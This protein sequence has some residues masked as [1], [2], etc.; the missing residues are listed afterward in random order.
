MSKNIKK[1]LNLVDNHLSNLEE[2]QSLLEAI[3]SSTQDA[4]SVVNH[5]GEHIMINPAYTKIT[6][7]KAEDILGTNA[8]FDVGE[9]ESVHM[10]VLRTST[11]VTGVTIKLRPSGKIVIAQAA[12]IIVDNKLIGSVAGLKDVTE[13]NKLTNKLQ[14]AKKKIRELSAKYTFDDIIGENSL[15]VESKLEA[16]KAAKVPVTVLL[17]GESGTGKELF[18]HAI[19]AKSTRKNN[20]FIRVNCAALNESLLESELFG[21]VEGAFTGAKKGGKKGLFEEANKGTIFLDEISEI[22]FN[23]QVKLLR[24]LQEKEITRVGSTKSMPVDV[25]VIAATNINLEKAVRQGK[26]REDLY[27]RINI[28]PINIPSLKYRKDDIPLLVDEFIKKF[29]YEYGRNIKGIE[30]AA[31]KVLFSYDWPGNVRELENY[32]GRSIITMNF[33]EQIIKKVNL[34]HKDFVLGKA[35]AINDP[36]IGNIELLE[37]ITSKAEEEYIIKALNSLNSNKTETAKK[38]GISLRSLYYKLDKYNIL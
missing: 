11:P 30:D 2:Y 10:K 28:F 13:I 15:F 18:A 31:I 7:I 1:V 37:N 32:I 14:D 21:Y 17:R 20:Q 8:Y 3:F 5:L 38:L 22:N 34:P 25:R 33:N 35:I 24:V 27:Y 26:F 12:P 19:H 6:G 16:K 23:T 4:I 36:I 29:N 9:G